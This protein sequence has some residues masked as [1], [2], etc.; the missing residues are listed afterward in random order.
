M[1]IAKS[2][3]EYAAAAAVLS[4]PTPGGGGVG[5]AGGGDR[6]TTPVMSSFRPSDN[7][8]LYALPQDPRNVGYSTLRPTKKPPA[9][10]LTT[11]STP[12]ANS[13][14][15]SSRSKSLPPRSGRPS[16]VTVKSDETDNRPRVSVTVNSTP[17]IPDPDYGSEDE[18]EEEEE[19]QVST[20][21]QSRKMEKGMPKLQSFCTDILKAKS[22][23]LCICL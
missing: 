20:E 16:L 6:P 21:R 12:P 3:D 22:L 5:G 1:D 2:H 11:P 10:T 13:T 8:K 14:V 19:H 7:A 9:S 17:L 18:P 4:V 15:L 23:R